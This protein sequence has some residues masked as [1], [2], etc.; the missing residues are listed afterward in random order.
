MN[1]LTEQRA[2][3]IDL[4]HTL[5][6][7]VFGEITDANLDFSPGGTALTL[8]RLL[9]EQA[10][11]QAAYA[12]S[13]RTLKLKFDVVAPEEI[14]T[15][16]QIQEWFAQLDTEMFE[17]LDALSNED[18]SRPHE[19]RGQMSPRYT[20]EIS[21]HTYRESVLIFAA[22]ASVYLRALGRTLPKLMKSFVG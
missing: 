19:P 18:L 22:K 3:L 1:R 13:F 2:H 7:T 8:R 11:I 20:V 12:E 6:D 17:A 9:L 4:T 16:A 10:E 15:T 5:R 14:R 21:F